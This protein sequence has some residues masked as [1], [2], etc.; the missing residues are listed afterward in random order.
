LR[1]W[2]PDTP[3]ATAGYQLDITD[4]LQMDSFAAKGRSRLGDPSIV[5]HGVAL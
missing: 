1:P 3:A 4:W 5:I 2:Q